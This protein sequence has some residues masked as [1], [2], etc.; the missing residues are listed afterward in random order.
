MRERWFLLGCLVV[1][2]AGWGATLPLS[3]IAVSGDY[4]HVGVIFWQLLIGAVAMGAIQF[5]RGRK[6][7]LDRRALGI[8]V[9]IACIGTL[10]P[11]AASFEA[12][13]KLP[14]C[15]FSI[16]ISM[17]PILAFPVALVMRNEN[18]AWLR[19]F[20]LGMGL[21]GV[22]LIVGPDA[23]LPE[24]AMV[25]FVPL[26]LIAP[27]FYALEGNI[28][29]KWGTDGMDGI[30]VLFG[31]SFFGAILAFPLTLMTGTFINPLP[32]WG[33]PDFA[34]A[35]SSILHVTVYAAYVWL[36]GRAGPIFAAQVAYLVTG[37]GVFWS[38]L[39]LGERYSIWVW[40][41]MVVI[42]SGVFLVQP[43]LR[44]PLAETAET[45][46]S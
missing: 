13:L 9:L 46:Q 20:G 40:F 29:A 35:L 42:L 37:F 36:V 30:E 34:I 5:A 21:V 19:V 39:V 18:F 15:L 3:K 32:P 43:R 24:R 25:V 22:I 28:V 10:F 41:A 44:E 31:A 17:V 27:S 16:L 6:L 2:G 26:A 45:R 12:L 4:R 33:A 11:N 23:S 7:R 8:F 38:M 14:A 1:M